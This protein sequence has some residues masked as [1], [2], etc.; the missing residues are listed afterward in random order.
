MII[1]MYQKMFT[2]DMIDAD[3]PL[4]TFQM[5]PEAKMSGQE[6]GVGSRKGVVNGCRGYT[7]GRY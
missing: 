3:V 2:K 1:L 4:S 6:N 7:N 5:I